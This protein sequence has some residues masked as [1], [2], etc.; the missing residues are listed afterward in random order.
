ML[1]VVYISAGIQ[2][3]IE[4]MTTRVDWSGDIMQP[5]RTLSVTMANTNSFLKDEKI[6]LNLECGKEIRL[7]N[8]SAELFRGVI[9]DID[10]DEKGMTTITAYDEG[11]YLMQN[12]DT[13]IVKSSTASNMIKNICKEFGIPTGTV[14]DTGYVIASQVFRNDDLWTMFQKAITKTRDETGRR[15]WMYTHLGQLHL[16][17]RSDQIVRW[18]LEDDTNLTSASR[19]VNIEELRN[20]IKVMNGDIEKG[21]QKSA[22]AKDSDSVSRYGLMQHLEEVNEDVDS[23]KMNE[24]A[25]Y[26]LK[27]MNKPRIDI[28]VDAIGIDMVFAGK[29]VY[30]FDEKTGLNGGYYVQ[31]DSHSWESGNHT[32]SL[33]LSFTDELPFVDLFSEDDQKKRNYAKEY[34]T[35][36]SPTGKS[37]KGAKKSKSKSDSGPTEWT[38][39]NPETGL[40][41]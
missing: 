40:W 37:G 5:F 22:L 3:F 30:V 12:K 28:S 4:N 13:R 19:R 33:T 25:Q 7:Y 1:Q 16:V 31:T 17:L 11:K 34:T 41:E 10:V 6:Y 23:A 8:D 24:R 38:R 26:L 20:S 36:K 29:A 2:Y 27:D 21:T 14:D 15:Y 35:K 18:V 9:F 32:M 39:I